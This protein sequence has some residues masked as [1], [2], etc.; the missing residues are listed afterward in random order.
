MEK[1]V[2]VVMSNH[3]LVDPDT[4]VIRKLESHV[5]LFSR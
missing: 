3:G 4:N 5:E 2:D 1:R